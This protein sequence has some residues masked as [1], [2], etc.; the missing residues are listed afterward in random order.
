[1]FGFFVCR[2]TL[3]SSC[4][5]VRLRSRGVEGR[6]CRKNS[7]VRHHAHTIFMNLRA[8]IRG[9][10]VKRVLM[11]TS[12]TRFDF[13]II[14]V[15]TYFYYFVRDFVCNVFT[16]VYNYRDLCT[17]SPVIGFLLAFYL[18]FYFFALQS[19]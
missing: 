17:P 14:C 13:Y 1:M 6:I 3:D 5:D 16:H 18:F 12:C 15:H 7:R 10:C 9:A 11:I 2:L 19:E 8:P 4:T